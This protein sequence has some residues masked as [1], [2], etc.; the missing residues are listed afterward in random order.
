M[1]PN[2]LELRVRYSEVDAMGVAHNSAYLHWFEAGRT[3]W[4][5]ERGMSYR[6][7]EKRG[8]SLP[9]IEAVV[10]YLG[11]ARYDDVLKIVT[12]LRESRSRRL[13]F[14]YRIMLEGACIAEGSTAHVF[15]EIAS[16]RTVRLPAWLSS[17]L[18]R[19][20]GETEG[21]GVE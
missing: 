19:S 3:E 11:P 18:V 20:P 12:T 7:V 2:T 5:R 6:D 4:M 16:G 13:V 15:I 9:V 10:R 14:G 8:I 21:E 1:S 17:L